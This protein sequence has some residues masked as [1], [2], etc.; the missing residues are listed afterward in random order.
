MPY[1]TRPTYTVDGQEHY[2]D[3]LRVQVKTKEQLINLIHTYYM[4]TEMELDQAIIGCM[5]RLVSSPELYPGSRHFLYLL[6]QQAAVHE[7]E[8]DD[9]LVYRVNVTIAHGYSVSI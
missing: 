2:I 3:G 7:V 4:G 6:M 8:L 1:T 5:V 9:E